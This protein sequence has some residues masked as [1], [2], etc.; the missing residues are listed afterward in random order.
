MSQRAWSINSFWLSAWTR[1]GG[2][3]SRSIS[4]DW[5]YNDLKSP[6]AFVFALHGPV[7]PQRQLLVYYQ[8]ESGIPTLKCSSAIWPIS[9][10]LPSPAKQLAAWSFDGDTQQSSTFAWRFA[11][12]GAHCATFRRHTLRGWPRT[13]CHT[14]SWE[15]LSGTI[16]SFLAFSVR[17]N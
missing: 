8:R 10:E 12:W 3:Q 9:S 1:L 6:S 11:V 5:R 7:S 2:L 16:V 15:K 17:R 4:C 13:L 14:M